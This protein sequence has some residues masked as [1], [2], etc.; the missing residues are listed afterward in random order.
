MEAQGGSLLG[1]LLP[2]VV[3]FGIF[4]FLII[5]PQQKQAKDHKEMM[6]SLAVGDTIVTNGG[7]I[8]EITAIE[9]T[10]YTVKN[11]DGS[12]MKLALD[13]VANKLEDK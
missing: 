5:K 10:Y 6:N 1:S 2:L 9:E 7:V 3:L 11:V 12:Q 13:Y 4:Y 8:V